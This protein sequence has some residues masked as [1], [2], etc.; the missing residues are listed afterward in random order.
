VQYWQCDN[1]PC[2][3][4]LTWAGTAREYVT[5]L[6]I[7][8]RAVKRA[9]PYAAVVLGGSP[10]GLPS[11]PPDSSERQFFDHIL[12]E[13]REFFDLFD[14]HLYADAERIPADLEATRELMRAHGYQRP[15]VVGEYGAPTPE[16]FPA[17]QA[18]LHATMAAVTSTPPDGDTEAVTQTSASRTPEQ[19]AMSQ[20][21]ACM[22]GLPPELQMFMS[23]C[24]AELEA[25]R[26]R[27]HCR[28]V[29][30][31]NMHALASGVNA[32]AC[33]KLA[34]E[35]GGY[36]DRLSAMELF[37]GKLVLMGYEGGA[38]R[39]RHPAGETFALLAQQLAG[40]HRIARVQTPDQPR[41]RMFEV[42]SQGGRPVRWVIWHHGDPF[43]AENDA[44]VRFAWRW[45]GPSATAIDAF[46]QAVSVRVREGQIALEVGLT[47][48]FISAA[49]I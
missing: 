47:P 12:R 34:P 48:I 19:I 29:V 17:A 14:H 49:T 26:H 20:L 8:H 45:S 7:M 21:Y 38:L 23:G 37:Y 22:Q 4:G 24:S 33:W 13:G 35:V 5:Q 2:N 28:E 6:Q 30:M 16:Q 10:Y 9:D 31:R 15:I 3:V 11:S 1:E 39:N 41:I 43:H 25:R 42:Q 46:G 40:A 44:P 18:A 36:E 32:T 27:I